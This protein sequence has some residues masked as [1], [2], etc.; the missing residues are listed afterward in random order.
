MVV[1]ATSHRGCVNRA[2]EKPQGAVTCLLPHRRPCPDWCHKKLIE[3]SAQGVRG[4][5]HPV[6]NRLAV[7][8]MERWGQGAVTCWLLWW[9]GKE[10]GGT[11]RVHKNQWWQEV[12]QGDWT[13]QSPPDALFWNQDGKSGRL[14]RGERCPTGA[15]LLRAFYRNDSALSEN[16]TVEVKNN[17]KKK[18]TRHLGFTDF[19]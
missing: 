6:R 18:K 12:N 17:L 19:T 5:T 15:V 13:N 14:R 10:S 1:V 16:T 8:R 11:E 3:L 9:T 4:Q 2:W 7:S